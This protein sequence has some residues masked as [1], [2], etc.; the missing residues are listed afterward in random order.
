MSVSV[1]VRG[2]CLYVSLWGS[3]C[4]WLR[5]RASVRVVAWLGVIVCAL[6]C[7]VDCLC[8][9][10]FGWLSES[11][12]VCAVIVCNCLGGVACCVCVSCRLCARVL[13]QLAMR[14]WVVVC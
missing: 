12:F 9:W 4:C 2:V 1:C 8:A 3:M 6:V 7:V 5:V 10:S 14:Q 11:A 13:V